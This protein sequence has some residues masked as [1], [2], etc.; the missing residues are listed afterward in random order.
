MSTKAIY[1][2]DS[3]MEECDATIVDIEKK[4]K[5]KVN[6][7]L[8]K[9]NFLPSSRDG[10]DKGQIYSPNGSIYIKKAVIDHKTGLIT[11]SGRIENGNFEVGDSVTCKIDWDYRYPLMR[12]HSA[13]HVIYGSARSFIEQP[14]IGVSKVS[15]NEKY[16][17]WK[18]VIR[19][20]KG[21]EIDKFIANIIEKANEY[22]SNSIPFKIETFPRLEAINM[23]GDIFDFLPAEASDVRVISV[24]DLPPDPCRGLQVKNSAEIGPIHLIKHEIIDNSDI[25][26]FFDL[27]N[28]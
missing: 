14:F 22:I 9:T 20:I 2:D 1:V 13:T 25:K 12:A 3:Y 10:L 11:H 6:V 27:E 28:N 19:H 5:G 18:D 15:S 8:D 4:S 23:C 26:V 16:S 17:H 24:G 21:I 7:F